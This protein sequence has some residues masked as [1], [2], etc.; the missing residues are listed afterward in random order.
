VCR[1]STKEGGVLG[2]F[3]AALKTSAPESG[4]APATKD[5][6]VCLLLLLF[7]SEAVELRLKRKKKTLA[8]TPTADKSTTR[9]MLENLR[10]I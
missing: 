2:A 1:C 8:I 4:G 6:A 9:R 7:A 3:A 5:P 10:C